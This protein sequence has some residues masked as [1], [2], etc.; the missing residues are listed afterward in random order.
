MHTRVIVSIKIDINLFQIMSMEFVIHRIEGYGR[1]S[2]PCM[3]P[4]LD[5][6]RRLYVLVRF[7][8]EIWIVLDLMSRR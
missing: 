6:T 8:M 7:S 4:S 5:V 2:V 3:M 1:S